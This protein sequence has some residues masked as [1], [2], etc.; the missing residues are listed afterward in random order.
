MSAPIKHTCPDIDRALKHLKDAWREIKDSVEDKRTRDN[1]EWELDMVESIL[2]D[3]R[4]DNGA[5]RDW[6]HDLEKRNGELEDEVYNL[7]IELKEQQDQ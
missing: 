2:E 5:L 4:K 1:I 3:L 7:E 6:G